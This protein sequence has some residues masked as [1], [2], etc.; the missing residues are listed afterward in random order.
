MAYAA[1]GIG[2]QR[3]RAQLSDSRCVK[4]RP[5]SMSNVFLIRLR[6]T[7]AF[8]PNG[9]RRRVARRSAEHRSLLAKLGSKAFLN[10]GNHEIVSS[11]LPDV[12]SG[13]GMVPRPR[14]HGNVG[15]M[16]ARR[17]RLAGASSRVNGPTRMTASSV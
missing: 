2:S 16:C 8:P 1:A 12:E 15:R 11:L 3:T 6:R 17:K 10:Q 7:M 13:R 9:L 14:D 4:L 5:G